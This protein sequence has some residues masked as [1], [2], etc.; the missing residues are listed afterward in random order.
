M[1]FEF[2]LLGRNIYLFVLGYEDDR[3]YGYNFILCRRR[4]C[5]TH[6][7][8]LSFYSTHVYVSKTLLRFSGT[9]LSLLGFRGM[10]NIR[11]NRGRHRKEN[12]NKYMY[13]HFIYIYIFTRIKIYMNIC[14]QNNGSR[15]VGKPRKHLKLYAQSGDDGGGEG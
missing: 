2:L 14:V 1:K 9:R 13:T 7:N 3:R 12:I 4:F 15:R 11:R 10:E 6:E 8:S 5:N